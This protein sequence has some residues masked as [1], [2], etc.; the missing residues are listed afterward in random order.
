LKTGSASDFDITLANKSEVFA[1]NFTG[2]INVPTDGQYTFYTSSDD[3][4]LLYID[5]ILIVNND[6]QHGIQERSGVIGLKAGKHAISVG[7]F[8]QY[9]GKVLTVS[10]EGPG[11][12]KQL[13]PASSLFRISPLLPA[14]NPDNT[15]NGIDYKYYEGSSYNVV[16][17]FSTLTPLK[18]G[19]ASDFDITL[20]NKSEVFAFNF[21]GY[22]NVPSDGQY[23]FYTSSDDG[24]LLYIDG[25]LVVN[26]D[27]IHGIQERSGVIGLKAGKHAIS[28]GFF[29]Q[30]QGKVLTVSYAGPGIAKQVIPASSLFRTSIGSR[31]TNI[32]SQLA[33]IP[34]VAIAVDS[35][36]SL[37]TINGLKV[38]AYP[39]PFVNSVKVIINGEAGNYQ[40]MLTD[41]SGKTLRVEN[42]FKNAG[43]YNLIINTSSF[44]HGIYFLR[45]IQNNRSSVI[46]L[47]K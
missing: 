15:V 36:A 40:L 26:N 6:Q 13:I 7:F 24:S 18:T 21:T 37:S 3:G 45:V 31:M 1:F 22:I 11:I 34:T 20:A 8:Q 38:K 16:P 46:K 29:Q 39:N 12:S 30:Y 44:Q 2:Y 43:N 32:S 4:S 41:A 28:V 25:T 47:E 35:T 19:S 27:Q 10:Y 33:T 23:T 42:G 9:Q 14:V 5:G 17:D